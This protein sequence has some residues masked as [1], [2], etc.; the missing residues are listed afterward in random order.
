[1][2]KLHAQP[3]D[4]TANGFFFESAEEYTQ[5]ANSCRNDFGGP[6]EEFELQFIDGEDID[7][8]LFRAL[9]INQSNFEAFF[10][11]A[12][13][14]D[15]FDKIKLIIATYECGYRF[16]LA[17]DDPEDLDIDIYEIDTLRELAEQFV[18]EGL[19][20]EIPTHLQYY[21]DYEAIARDL[22]MDYC[23][24]NVAGRRLIFRAS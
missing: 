19:F 16:D 9:D 7:A 11:K 15:E 14:L 3:Y 23:E 18:D 20:G 5:K 13:D 12:E 22:A 6:I 1:M 8:A 4:I 21:I 24:T 2:I 10:E 17:E